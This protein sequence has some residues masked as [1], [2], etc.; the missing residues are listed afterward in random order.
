MSHEINV[1]IQ[2]T[3]D[4]KARMMMLGNTQQL[5]HHTTGEFQ[6]TAFVDATRFANALGV[7]PTNVCLMRAA[8]N[9]ESTGFRRIANRYPTETREHIDADA[10]HV[11]GSGTMT[12]LQS[13]DCASGVVYKPSTQESILFH[14]GRPA[15]MPIDGQNII[16][17]V[18]DRIAPDGQVD[19]LEVI[20]TGLICGA[21]LPHRDGL[22]REQADAYLAEFG[23]DV[24]YDAETR[25]LDLR[26][27]II[28]THVRAGLETNQI[29]FFGPDCTFADPCCAS[30]RRD[31]VEGNVREHANSIVWIT[32]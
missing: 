17:D 26:K 2:D 9:V 25:S 1:F 31:L 29:K 4:Q 20:C 11:R 7:Q 15:G 6:P 28:A 10:I 8:S 27:V 30:N 32:K 5:W 3:I 16:T 12:M 18:L 21:H 13:A 19:E 14:V 23:P 24:F 22:G